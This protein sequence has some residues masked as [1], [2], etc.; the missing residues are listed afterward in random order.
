MPRP[1]LIDLYY[2]LIE[3]APDMGW[4]N[5]SAALL[6][7]TPRQLRDAS[8]PS[9][10][11]RMTGAVASAEAVIDRLLAELGRDQPEPELYARLVAKRWEYFH[12]ITLFPDALPALDEL[13]ARGH[14]L[15]LVTNC[16][17]E[18]SHTLERLDLARR[19]DALSL[20]CD[21]RSAKPDPGIYQHAI[22]A[23]GIDPA[24]AVYVGD[25]D[26]DEH[27]GAARFG[28][29]T[30]LLQRPGAKVRPVRADWTIASL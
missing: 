17:V 21:V 3:P 9:F 10:N 12:G 24:S 20:S 14:K 19:F 16:S 13:R 7:V 6:G 8:M 4:F 30:V 26:T 15:A 18:T 23:L 28:M 22:D 25:G 29:T 2:T 11:D 5:D 27:A 1:V